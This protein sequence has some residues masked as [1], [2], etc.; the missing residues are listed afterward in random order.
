MKFAKL[1]G[2]G[3]DFLVALGADV[4][5]APQSLSL[6]ARNVCQRNTGIG[7]DGVVFYRPTVG[8]A[9]SDV[10]ALIYNADGSRAEMSGNGMR[11]LA[12]YLVHSGADSSR[13]LRIRTVSGIKRFTLKERTGRAYIFESSLGIPILDP[14]R[15][16]VNLGLRHEPVIGYALE[17][18]DGVVPVTISSMGNPH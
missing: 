4:G 13:S 17:V 3:N 8:D 11:C 1:H 18:E 12:A 9:D 5:S 7:A 6:L 14:A 10:S 15:I 16:P 2:L